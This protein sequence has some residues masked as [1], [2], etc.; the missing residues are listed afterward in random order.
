MESKESVVARGHAD[1]VTAA[2]ARISQLNHAL[3]LCMIY[4][5]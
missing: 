3:L 2:T 4:T 5:P 1:V